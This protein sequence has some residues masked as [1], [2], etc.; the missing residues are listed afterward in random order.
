MLTTTGH[1]FCKQTPFLLFSS[2]TRLCLNSTHPTPKLGQIIWKRS[3]NGPFLPAN[4]QVHFTCNN[5][6]LLDNGEVDELW[7][8]DP[9]TAC[10]PL[11][12]PQ[13]RPLILTC[14]YV[15]SYL[16]TSLHALILTCS[17]VRLL[18]AL[19]LTR[20]TRILHKCSLTLTLLLLSP[21]TCTQH[22]DSSNMN[23][24]PAIVVV[25]IRIW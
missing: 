13:T 17:Y 6:H 12:P 22:A 9:F 8:G 21:F 2:Q 11:N 7:Q 24:V 3:W 16:L 1:H 14:S 4:Q 19:L 18:T 20:T 5:P 23:V 15:Y 25:Y 10:F